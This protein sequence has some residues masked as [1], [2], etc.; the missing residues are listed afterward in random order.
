VA[1]ALRRWIQH[2][3]GHLGT[4]RIRVPVSLHHEGDDAGNRDSFF[5][6]G[7]PLGEPDPIVRL[8]AVHA[9]TAVRK[10]DHDAETM[11]ELLQGLARISPRLQRFCAQ[12]EESPRQF[13]VSVSNVVGPADPVA[14]LGAPVEG[15][16]SI[17]E[18]G[19]RHALRVGVVSLCGSLHF[20]FCAD[21]GIVDDIQAMA[22]GVEVEAEALIDAAA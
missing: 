3:H 7:V 10:A 22:D 11:D 18:I 19:E 17:A 2:H 16:Y 9:A 14:V 5:S 1:G 21:P 12:L 20:G 8:R 4:A 13:A 6:V 15:L